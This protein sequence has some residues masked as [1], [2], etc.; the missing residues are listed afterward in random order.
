MWNR[1]RNYLFLLAA[2]AIAALGCQGGGDVDEDQFVPQREDVARALEVSTASVRTHDLHSRSNGEMAAE[3]PAELLHVPGTSADIEA[4][5]R[6]RGYLATFV[7]GDRSTVR[8]ATDL[9]GTVAA[10]QRALARE[11][12]ASSGPAIPGEPIG[13]ESVIWPEGRFGGQPGCPCQLQI[14]VGSVIVAITISHRGP[15][16]SNEKPDQA[17]TRLATIL[18]ERLKE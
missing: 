9:Y 16:P 4:A 15:S 1:G 3:R 13:D 17:Q 12:F 14:R 11:P 2:G 10:A 18:A 8:V 6:I 7:V 5:G